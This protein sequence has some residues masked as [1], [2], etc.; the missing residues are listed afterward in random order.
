MKMTNL[1]MRVE[2]DLRKEADAVFAAIGL[3]TPAAVRVFLKKAVSVRGI[4]FSLSAEEPVRWEYVTADDD[5]RVRMEKVDAAWKII[6]A[7]KG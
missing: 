1:Q 2:S 5:A 6:K 4:P 3:D 7:K